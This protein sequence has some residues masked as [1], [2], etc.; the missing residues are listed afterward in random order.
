LSQYQIFTNSFESSNVILHESNIFNA[1]TYFND[2]VYFS[3]EAILH[4][5]LYIKGSLQ[6]CS[7]ALI[8]NDNLLVSKSLH[9]NNSIAAPSL[10]ANTLLANNL[11]LGKWKLYRSNNVLDSNIDDL[12]IHN[13]NLN[14]SNNVA[15]LHVKEQL[16]VQ[17]DVLL[18][19][20]LSV[21]GEVYIN[22]VL[23]VVEHIYSKDATVKENL[24]ANTII[25]QGSNILDLITNTSTQNIEIN[26]SISELSNI[27][28]ENLNSNVASIDEKIEELNNLINH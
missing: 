22:S 20:D 5:N 16:H 15:T 28:S 14:D 9:V 17:N 21:N 24:Y 18:R 4:S 27:L 25:L 23:S 10:S 19:K 12:Y 11:D 7:N 6:S 8:I 2:K 13:F 26:S 3:N 1:E